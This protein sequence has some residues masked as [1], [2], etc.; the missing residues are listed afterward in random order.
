MLG[1]GI[2]LENVLALDVEALESAVDGGVEH[3][4]DAQAG[5]RDRA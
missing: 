4:G 5:L 1:V 3:I 2:G